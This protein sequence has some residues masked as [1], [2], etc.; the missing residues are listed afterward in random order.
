MSFYTI[1]EAIRDGLRL[2]LSL[3]DGEYVVEPHV[4]GRNRKGDALLRAYQVRGPR[5]PNNTTGWKLFRLDRISHAVETGDRFND[6][7][8]RYKPN[9]PTMRG[10]IIERL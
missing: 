5:K 10:G 9:D 2:R 6:P 4:L 3:S 8:P 7:R 1:K